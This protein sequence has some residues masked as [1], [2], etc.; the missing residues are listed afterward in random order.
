MNSR[1]YFGTAGATP[2]ND[3][4]VFEPIVTLDAGQVAAKEIVLLQTPVDIDNVF[5]MVIG[6]SVLDNLSLTG[7]TIDYSA[8]SYSASLVVGSQIQFIYKKV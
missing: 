1:I 8:S 4:L 2:G 6:G 5:A 3:N 7:N